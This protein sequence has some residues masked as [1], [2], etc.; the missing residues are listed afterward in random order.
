MHIHLE[1]WVKLC[2]KSHYPIKNRDRKKMQA[3]VGDMPKKIT[4]AYLV[5][6]SMCDNFI[7]PW[8]WWTSMYSILC[9]I[10]NEG[11]IENHLQKT[12]QLRNVI[13][14]LHQS[15]S[16]RTENVCHSADGRKIWFCDQI[17][18][19]LFHPFIFLITLSWL[20]LIK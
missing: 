16:C 3:A 12:I 4:K 17:A 19:V 20:F 9:Y 13:P 6:M 5:Q 2:I 7:H 15:K 10:M 1:K 11:F 8:R 18:A 14:S